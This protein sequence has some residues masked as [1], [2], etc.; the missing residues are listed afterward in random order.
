MKKVNMICIFFKDYDALR[1]IGYPFLLQLLTCIEYE[2]IG[3]AHCYCGMPI[4]S[5]C[6]P[7]QLTATS[8]GRK[9]NTWSAVFHINPDGLTHKFKSIIQECII[10]CFNIIEACVTFCS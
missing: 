2:F 9:A 5:P 8:G 10:G 6:T 1:F 7:M 3:N 4:C